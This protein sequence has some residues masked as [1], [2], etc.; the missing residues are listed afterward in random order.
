MTHR[1]AGDLHGHAA[2]LPKLAALAGVCIALHRRAVRE[3]L[4]GVAYTSG[5]RCRRTQLAP[6]QG[7]YPLDAP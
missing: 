4:A 3:Q 7:G 1:A 2:D 6:Q 5:L